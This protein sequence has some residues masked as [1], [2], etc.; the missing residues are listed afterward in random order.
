MSGG[1]SPYKSR[2][3]Y[4]TH[5][6]S[7][8]LLNILFVPNSFW[9]EAG[10]GEF[11]APHLRHLLTKKID[12]LTWLNQ[13]LYKSGFKRQNKNCMESSGSSIRV[14]R[15]VTAFPHTLLRM[16]LLS[17]P[18]KTEASFCRQSSR[19]CCSLRKI[20]THICSD[21]FSTRAEATPVQ[22][23]NLRFQ[24]GAAYLLEQSSRKAK[25]KTGVE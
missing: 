22:A 2:Y 17:S 18:K 11:G 19:L 25:R 5:N 6:W 13:P 23:L 12:L 14:N 24:H 4:D 9:L 20:Q 7:S 8:L 10:S 3:V 15:W 1:K 21:Q 16:K